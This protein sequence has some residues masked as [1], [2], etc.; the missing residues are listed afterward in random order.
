MEIPF[1]SIH[2]NRYSGA[3]RQKVQSAC[4]FSYVPLLQ[5]LSQLLQNKDVQNEMHIPR[6]RDDRHLYDFQSGSAWKEHPLF[7]VHQDTLQIIAYYDELEVTNQ[8][9]HM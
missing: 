1:A 6:C 3:K 7:T 4:T 5:T 8:L 9:D 2:I